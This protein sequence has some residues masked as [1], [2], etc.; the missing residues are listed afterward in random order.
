MCCAIAKAKLSS[1]KQAFDH[2]FAQN[3]K[4]SESAGISIWE[5]MQALLER[6]GGRLDVTTAMWSAQEHPFSLETGLI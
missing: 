3:M 1:C 4:L 5:G 2:C 6:G